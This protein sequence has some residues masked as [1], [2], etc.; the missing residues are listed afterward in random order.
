MKV[1]FQNP[2]Q[3]NPFHLVN[4]NPFNYLKN[5]ISGVYVY[6]LLLDINNEKKFIPINVGESSDIKTRILKHYNGVV[7]RTTNKE[8][9]NVVNPSNLNEI[10]K[11]YS[12]IHFYDSLQSKKIKNFKQSPFFIKINTLNKHLIYFQSPDFYRFKGI[13]FNGNAD[14]N[15][16]NTTIQLRNCGCVLS[17]QLVNNIDNVCDLY[18]NN[19]YF[20]FSEKF[21]NDKNIENFFS[22]NINGNGNMERK[23]AETITKHSLQKIQIETTS[24]ILENYEIKNIDSINLSNIQQNLIN[25]TGEP[26]TNP[27]IL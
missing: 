9:F 10:G 12:S 20:I 1:T 21:I 19:F 13:K 7:N 26:F 17:Q 24:P 4:N 22:P 11:L 15:I 6:G 16:L 18:K 27:L 8:L 25:L 23:I 2:L 5:K 14:L 3:G